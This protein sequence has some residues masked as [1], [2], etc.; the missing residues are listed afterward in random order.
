M[1]PRRGP[2]VREESISPKIASCS[3]VTLP[4]SSAV[5][6]RRMYDVERERL[7]AQLLL[8]VDLDELDQV[9]LALRR[10]GGRRAGGGRRRCAA[11]SR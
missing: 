7:E 6:P 10:S 3:M 1:P 5:V 9:L 11:P 2:P 8:A 4:S